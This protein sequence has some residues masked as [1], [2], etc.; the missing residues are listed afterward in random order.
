M[1]DGGRG[2]TKAWSIQCRNISF[3]DLLDRT[4]VSIVRDGS[5][6]NIGHDVGSW[7]SAQIGQCKPVRATDLAVFL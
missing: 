2:P 1:G 3:D 6:P 4:A 7:K 5:R